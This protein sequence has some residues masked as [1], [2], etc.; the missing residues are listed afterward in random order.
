MAAA[1]KGLLW[2]G[3]HWWQFIIII[4]IIRFLI[5][6]QVQGQHPHQW[7]P[8]QIA[9]LLH[10]WQISH[11]ISTG[12]S[13][14]RVDSREL[15]LS[16]IPLCQLLPCHVGPPRPTLS[17][18]LYVKGCLDCTIGAFH[19]SI[20]A[21]PSLPQNE[22]QILNA[23]LHKQ[24]IGPGGDN[25]LWSN[26]AD[27]S[28]HCPIIPLQM[29]EVWL[30]QWPSLTGMEHCAPCTRAVHMVMCLERGGRKTELAAAP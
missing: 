13:I 21:E 23:K 10:A 4:I 6:V 24:L 26:I 25:V 12:M 18:N 17:L 11:Q 5:R 7:A 14:M 9:G 29:L 20:Q 1:G 3:D 8:F 2:K 16:A 22:V 30:C 27:L 28:D 15:P 19:M